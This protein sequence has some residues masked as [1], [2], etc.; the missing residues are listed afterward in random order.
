MR[1]GTQGGWS[2][3]LAAVVGAWAGAAMAPA[4]TGTAAP[5]PAAA[6]PKPERIGYADFDEIFAQ[7]PDRAAR[8]KH[9]EDVRAAAEK[10][11]QKLDIDLRDLDKEASATAPTL[12]KQW[13]I[14]QK[15]AETSAKL[16]ARRDLAEM[17]IMW[18]L[19]QTERQLREDIIKKVEAVAAEKGCTLVLNRAVQ[20]M[21]P[22]P[23]RRE[24]ALRRIPVVLS[25][26]PAA[27][28]TDA[29]LVKLRQK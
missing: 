25:G 23:G 24:P 2:V 10:D 9:I 12:E 22:V 28:L 11:I 19:Q 3:V 7:Y 29:V 8:F 4:T 21:Q 1:I 14:Q 16:K 18:H 17:E 5:A 15:I 20:A 27:N 6:A 13:P 26:D